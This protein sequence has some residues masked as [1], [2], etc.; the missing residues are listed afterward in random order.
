MPASK[1]L[2]KLLQAT[3][4]EERGFSK[5]KKTPIDRAAQRK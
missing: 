3:R 5:N 4:C 2:E 1:P